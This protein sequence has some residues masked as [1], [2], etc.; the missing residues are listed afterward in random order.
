MKLFL[1]K[2]DVTY[3]DTRS[4]Y[5]ENN[6]DTIAHNVHVCGHPGRRRLML[7]HCMTRQILTLFSAEL[8]SSHTLIGGI[9]LPNE[10]ERLTSSK[11]LTTKRGYRFCADP[12]VDWVKEVIKIKA[13]TLS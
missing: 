2:N 3:V 7:R 6:K 12:E 13:P 11:Y 1:E 8:D 4:V 10:L 5:T 9:Y